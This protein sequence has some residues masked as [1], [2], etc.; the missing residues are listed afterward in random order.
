MP[1]KEWNASIPRLS[2]EILNGIMVWEFQQPK[3][4]NIATINL[5][6]IHASID[7]EL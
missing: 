1:L 5:I 4:W 2:N 3:N 7:F 6:G